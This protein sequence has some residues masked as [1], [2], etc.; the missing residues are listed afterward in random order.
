MVFP[1]NFLPSNSQPWGREVQKRIELAETAISRNERNG[2]ARDTQLAAAFD[3]LNATVLKSQQALNKVLSVEEAVY[4]PGTEEIDG[5]NIRANTIAANRISAGELV[6]FTVKTGYTDDQRVELNSSNIAFLDSNN[7]SAGTISASV[8]S[9]SQSSLDITTSTGGAGLFMTGGLASLS[10]YNGSNIQLGT[11]AEGNVNI[12]ANT[13]NGGIVLSAD[14]ITLSGDTAISLIDGDVTSNGRITAGNFFTS[15]GLAGGGTTGASVNNAG[16][17]IRTTSS[18]RYKQDIED[19]VFNYE[20]I[21]ALQPK[22]FRLKE[23]AA[24]DDNARRYAG[25]IAEDIAGTALD[26]FVA[27]RT[28]ENGEQ[29]PDGV[30]YAE[31]TSALLSAIKHQDEKIKSLEARLEALESRV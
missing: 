4:Y 11:G 13:I 1:N 18:A 19:S 20:D 27:Y 26:I 10:A 29:E 2:D 30:Y 17:I 14:Y 22:T 7:N 5:G 8:Q 31:L 23:E 24:E 16:S 21:L 6:G 25:F 28:N 3:R 12:S 9:P 15:L